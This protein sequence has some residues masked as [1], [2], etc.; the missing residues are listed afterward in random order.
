MGRDY[1]KEDQV[2]G[3]L[4]DGTSVAVDTMQVVLYL[5]EVKVACEHLSISVLGGPGVRGQHAR[6]PP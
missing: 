4:M 6:H 1:R 5:L 2:L 3:P